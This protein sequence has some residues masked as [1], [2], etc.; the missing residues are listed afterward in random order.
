M[1]SWRAYVV[2]SSLWIA[3]ALAISLL[4]YSKQIEVHLQNGAEF[5]FPLDTPDSVVLEAVDKQQPDYADRITVIRPP[6]SVLRYLVYLGEIA[7]VP[8]AIGWLFLFY[9]VPILRSSYPRDS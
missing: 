5:R 8:P 9:L 7:F 2:A 1:N 4:N 6:K 3:G